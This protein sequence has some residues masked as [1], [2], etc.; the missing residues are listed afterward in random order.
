MLPFGARVFV[1]TDLMKRAPSTPEETLSP[2]NAP[3]PSL[4]MS[5]T[6]KKK[7]NVTQIRARQARLRLLSEHR[8]RAH[9]A[10]RNL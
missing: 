10:V 7:R 6:G 1:C 4:A 9:K 8:R 3:A 2:T 5:L